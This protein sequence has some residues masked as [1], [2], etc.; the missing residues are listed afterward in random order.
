MRP[1]IVTARALSNGPRETSTAHGDDERITEATVRRSTG[2]F[3]EVVREV[4]ARR[5]AAATSAR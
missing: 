5:P 3:Y 4:V 1:L 2:V